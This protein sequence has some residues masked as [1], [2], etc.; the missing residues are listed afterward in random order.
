[1]V[2]ISNHCNSWIVSSQP[3]RCT[4]PN[5]REG[6][7][8]MGLRH[9]LCCIGA[10]PLSKDEPRDE[11]RVRCVEPSGSGRAEQIVQD[12]VRQRPSVTNLSHKSQSAHMLVTRTTRPTRINKLQKGWVDVACHDLKTANGISTTNVLSSQTFP[13]DS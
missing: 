13:L 11:A 7:E 8:E 6:W 1:M 4:G 10:V 3:T 12:H 5:H 9:D 2:M